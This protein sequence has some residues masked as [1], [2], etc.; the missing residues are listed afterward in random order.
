MIVRGPG[1][2]VQEVPDA[3]QV[4]GQLGILTGG[5]DG[6]VAAVLEQHDLQLTLLS[7][8]SRAVLVGSQ[9]LVGGLLG[10]GL[11]QIQLHAVEQLLVIGQVGGLDSL[12]AVFNRGGHIGADSGGQ[13]GVS[14]A[15]AV[16]V[17]VGL[18]FVPEGVLVVGGGGQ[19]DG[20]GVSTGDSQLAAGAGDR[21]ALGD[22]RQVGCVLQLIVAD[23]ALQDQGV[24]ALDHGGAVLL[25]GEAH[26]QI[27]LGRAVGLQAG[28]QNVVIMADEELSGILGAVLGEGDGGDAGGQV[29]ISLIVRH[30]GR[31]AGVI[32]PDIAPGL[33]GAVAGAGADQLVAQGDG[34]T[35][36]A[37]QEQL[38]DLLH[39][40]TVLTVGLNVAAHVVGTAG[41]GTT[42]PQGLFVEGQMLADDLAVDIGAHVA[43]A[44]GQ[45]LLLP[46][47]G[48][49]SIAVVR[50][51]REDVGSLGCGLV[52]PQS[53]GV[54]LGG[55]RP[56]RNRRERHEAD[57]HGGC[58]KTG[59]DPL[60]DFHLL[61]S[62]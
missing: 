48:T 15:G 12:I 22:D 39:D 34:L 37:G 61:S 29:Q 36:A 11:T 16:V 23:L 7:L 17:V 8:G 55:F 5:G 38:L 20:D 60:E 40:G 57:R 3:L 28:H 52:I 24:I 26:I 1:G 45:S 9:Q 21:A 42:G 50:T 43:A 58:H 35:G 59:C 33:V 53:E 49:V 19:V 4:A 30:A 47:V 41:A 10:N 56:D 32:E 25:G 31:D 51:G 14:L 27:Q 13:L 6:Q 18:V 46:G 54:F 2:I 62:F 44:D